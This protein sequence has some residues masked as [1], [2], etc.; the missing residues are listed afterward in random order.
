MLLKKKIVFCIT[1]CGLF[2]VAQSFT[3]KGQHDNEKAQNLKVLP[4]DISDD[5]LHKVMHDF[6]V[7]LGVRCNHCHVKQETAAGEKPKMDFASDAKPE[8]GIARE[9]MKM[10]DGINH[11]YMSKIAEGNLEPVTCVTCHNGH[12]KPLN[13]VDSLIKKN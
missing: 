9:M 10:V 3:Q 4:K 12:V 7:S 13:T 5:D 8:K 2:L 1:L 11:T 6:S